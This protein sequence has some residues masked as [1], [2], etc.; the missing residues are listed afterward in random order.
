MS[1]NQLGN[2]IP[3]NARPVVVPQL[4]NSIPANA[5]RLGNSMNVNAMNVDGGRRRTRARKSSKSRKVHRQSKRR[6]HSRRRRD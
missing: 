6:S 3:A 1:R 4:G 5:R 2:S